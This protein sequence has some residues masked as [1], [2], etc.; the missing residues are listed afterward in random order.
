MMDSK[1][2]M[3]PHDQKEHNATKTESNMSNKRMAARTPPLNLVFIIVISA[4]TV[5]ALAVA[6]ISY[7]NTTSS[8]YILGNYVTNTFALESQRTFIILI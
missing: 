2:M 3:S 5:V 4:A 8:G 1:G 6:I 7:T